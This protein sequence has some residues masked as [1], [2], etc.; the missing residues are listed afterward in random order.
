[1]LT[2]LIVVLS[3]AVIV[4]VITRNNIKEKRGT[5]NTMFSLLNGVLLFLGLS[6][7]FLLMFA[8]TITAESLCEEYIKENIQEY[9]QENAVLEDELTIA[10]NDYLKSKGREMYVDSKDILH[11]IKLYPELMKDNEI[12]LKVNL[13][14][15]NVNC[16]KQFKL[17]D[18]DK[19]K[20]LLYFGP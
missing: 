7:F 6:L 19:N 5:Q 20:W 13:Y 14:E 11:I 12:Y 1:M 9:E 2:C 8:M 16:L 4:L 15:A 17:I 3:I 10:L 18:F